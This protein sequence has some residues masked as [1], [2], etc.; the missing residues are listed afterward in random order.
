MWSERAS[1]VL[2]E[3]RGAG[4]LCATRDVTIFEFFRSLS[5][6]CCFFLKKKRKGREKNHII[7]GEEEEERA[8][9]RRARGVKAAFVNLFSRFLLCVRVCVYIYIYIYI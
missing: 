1:P 2:S 3:S 8:L 5:S 6:L 9:S 7:E 4:F